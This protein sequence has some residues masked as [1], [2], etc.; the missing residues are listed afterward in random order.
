MMIETDEGTG[1]CGLCLQEGMGRK[2][3]FH[4]GSGRSGLRDGL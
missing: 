2:D 3:I 1:E 4:C